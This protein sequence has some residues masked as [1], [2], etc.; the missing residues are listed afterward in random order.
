MNTEEK[1]LNEALELFSNK[2]FSASSMREIA[3]NVDIKASSIYNHFKSKEEIL[4]RLINYYTVSQDMIKSI[5][6]QD[7]INNPMKTLKKIAYS[8]AFI[9]RTEFEL[10]VK[11]L[12]L[13]EQT[14][15]EIA[16]D[17][18]LK[19]HDL[20]KHK[21]LPDIFKILIDDN[22]IKDIDLSILTEQFIA[23]LFMNQ[24]EVVLLNITEENRKKK[25][26]KHVDFFWDN[27]KK[28]DS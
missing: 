18:L 28:I 24:M 9:G 21:I 27:I 2:G 6:K 10:K 23:P 19:K 7:I 17:E 11:R 14:R 3:K 26:D 16:R 22:K 4:L 1:I 8:D 12:I 13:I 20:M 5:N 15:V 25:I